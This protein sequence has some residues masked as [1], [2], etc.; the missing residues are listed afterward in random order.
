MIR[1]LLAPV[2][3]FAEA[4]S[5]LASVLTPAERGLLMRSLLERTLAL[6]RESNLFARLLVVS[7][8][9]LVWEVARKAGRRHAAGAGRGFEQR[10]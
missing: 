10:A 2:K 6:A 3:P 9:P 5:R 4:K 8:D 7:R 1:W